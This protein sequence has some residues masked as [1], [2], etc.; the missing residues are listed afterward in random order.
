MDD[1]PVN[2]CASAANEVSQELLE[3]GNHIQQIEPES[4]ELFWYDAHF[5]ETEPSSERM[6]KSLQLGSSRP[7]YDCIEPAQH[8]SLDDMSSHCHPLGA[9][10]LTANGK[11]NNKDDDDDDDDIDMETMKNKFL[12]AWTNAK[13]GW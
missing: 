6:F 12:S 1:L 5:G 3:D 7:A 10:G 9:K 4:E 11:S 2:N 13:N 8:H